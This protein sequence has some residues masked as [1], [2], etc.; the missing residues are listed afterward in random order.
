MDPNGPVSSS[1][2]GASL[3]ALGPFVSRHVGPSPD[4]QEEMLKVLGASSLDE[5]VE[6]CLPSSLPRAPRLALP[7]PLD[8]AGVAEA[9]R[10]LAAENVPSTCLVGMGFGAAR[11]PAVIRRHVLENPAWYTAY[12]PYQAE[13]S[14]GRLEALLN[15][16]T[17]V[18]DLTGCE[19]ANASLLDESSA[20]A[21]GLA[22]AHRVAPEKEVK[23]KRKNEKNRKVKM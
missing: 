19:I 23:E 17:M 12:T 22:L 10:A 20:V 6:Q 14:Q 15:F 21:E 2:P 16:Q 8:E 1:E 7:D 18:A 11:T 3:R 5:L 9:L 13:I 4:E